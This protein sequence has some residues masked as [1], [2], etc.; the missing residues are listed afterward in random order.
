MPFDPR[1]PFPRL[2]TW[3]KLE[4]M[5]HTLLS[6][7]VAYGGAKLLSGIQTEAYAGL[8]LLAVLLIPLPSI[9]YWGY[10]LWPRTPRSQDADLVAAYQ[11]DSATEKEQVQGSLAHID[12]GPPRAR[13]ALLSA[14]GPTLI[15]KDWQPRSDGGDRNDDD[16]GSDSGLTEAEELASRA[17]VAASE[18]ARAGGKP[19]RPARAAPQLRGAEQPGAGGWRVGAP[20]TVADAA[21]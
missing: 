6:I 8:A 12:S 5:V 4:V 15:L 9:I 19:V 11:S 14:G 2:L 20:V 18:G 10:V 7:P 21:C 17:V 16:S 13:L 3:P 1:I